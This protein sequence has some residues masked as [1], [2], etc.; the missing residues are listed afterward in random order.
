MPAHSAFLSFRAS[1]R[2]LAVLVSF[3]SLLVIN[4]QQ[5]WRLGDTYH[6]NEFLMSEVL[7]DQL[8]EFFFG[9]DPDAFG[10]FLELFLG[11]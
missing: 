1:I 6:I 10:G 5:S 7:R 2:A 9:L 8:S 4:R 11:L 3:T